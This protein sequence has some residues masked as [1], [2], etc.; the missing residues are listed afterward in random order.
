MIWGPAGRIFLCDEVEKGAYRAAA[1]H[2]G[3]SSC[4][5]ST[6]GTGRSNRRGWVVVEKARVDEERSLACRSMV[7][8]EAAAIFT[9]RPVFPVL[10]C[11]MVAIQGG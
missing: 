6:D 10:W 9:N 7:V 3:T 2:D 5:G 1:D 4:F 8:L 11:L